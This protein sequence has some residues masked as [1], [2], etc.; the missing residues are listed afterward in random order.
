MGLRRGKN[1][2]KDHLLQN[3]KIRF[4]QFK[5][6]PSLEYTNVYALETRTGTILRIL[7]GLVDDQ[8]VHVIQPKVER[9]EI[10]LI[11]K[12]LVDEIKAMQPEV[13]AV[14]VEYT[15]IDFSAMK[16]SMAMAITEL[17]KYVLDDS[18]DVHVDRQYH[19]EQIELL[20]AF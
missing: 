5:D 9:A 7:V 17:E 4:I 18:A 6:W 15:G 20:L 14:E 19:D 11:F 10:P 2:D 12:N 16:A 13:S 3:G 8:S 1:R